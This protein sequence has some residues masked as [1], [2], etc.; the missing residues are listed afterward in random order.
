[1]TALLDVYKITGK[2]DKSV[3]NSHVKIRAYSHMLEMWVES[4]I[5]FMGT[6]YHLLQ[7]PIQDDVMA[8]DEGDII[9][10][11]EI[12][13][14][15]KI[16]TVLD[17]ITPAIFDRHRFV[18]NITNKNTMDYLKYNIPTTAYIAFMGAATIQ[19]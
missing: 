1:M 6:H 16:T 4:Y 12:G 8:G 7:S 19:C 13:D 11:D 15:F 3:R 18:F 9:V 2:I 5:I 14:F 17:G 10:T